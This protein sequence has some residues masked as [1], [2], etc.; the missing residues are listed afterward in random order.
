MVYG[1]VGTGG[2]Q[3]AFDYL[4]MFDYPQTPTAA[5]LRAYAMT[6]VDGEYAAAFQ[7]DWVICVLN[8][9]ASTAKSPCV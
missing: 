7:N 6:E 8:F 3:A 9:N 5:E 1:V 2:W 4:K